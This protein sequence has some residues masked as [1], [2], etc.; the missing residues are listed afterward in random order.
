MREAKSLGFKKHKEGKLY[1]AI[2]YDESSDAW[3]NQ[4]SHSPC[5]SLKI[6]TFQYKTKNG[7][8]HLVPLVLASENIR[9]GEALTLDLGNGGCSEAQTLKTGPNGQYVHSLYLAPHM[10]FPVKYALEKNGF[11]DFERADSSFNFLSTEEAQSFYQ[12]SEHAFSGEDLPFRLKKS[13]G[14]LG[15]KILILDRSQ[16]PIEKDE[17]I[18]LA[19][20]VYEFT[21]KREFYPEHLLPVITTGISKTPNI[22]PGGRAFQLVTPDEE[23]VLIVNLNKRGN[24]TR[25]LRHKEDGNLSYVPRMLLIDGEVMPGL[26]L[27]ARKKIYPGEELSVFRVL[28]SH[29][30]NPRKRK[31]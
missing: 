12:W 15:E 25:T 10:I 14:A 30:E 1:V 13:V 27:K 17:I 18:S 26:A 9:Q 6:Q 19:T 31:R 24:W 21:P 16:K 28:P 29:K 2:C 3:I 22:T 8:T 5:A 20:G 23:H 4:V 7:Q 11:L